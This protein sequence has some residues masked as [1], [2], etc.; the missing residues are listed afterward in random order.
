MWNM[1]VTI[2]PIV[3]SALGETCCHSKTN[4]KSSADDVAKNFEMGN[5]IIII[6]IIENWKS[7]GTWK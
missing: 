5:I 7:C 6:I 1:K 4:E 2:V 3:I